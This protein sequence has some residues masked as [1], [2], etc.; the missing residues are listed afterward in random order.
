MK[1]DGLEV[2]AQTRI[3]PLHQ[4]CR[5]LQGDHEIQAHPASEHNK[6]QERE[7]LKSVPARC[8]V[9]AKFQPSKQVC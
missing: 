4:L 9:L 3:L 7:R 8:I 2:V 6:N 1:E 5:Q